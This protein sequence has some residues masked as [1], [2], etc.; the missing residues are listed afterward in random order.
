MERKARPLFH[1]WDRIK[2][3]VQLVYLNSCFNK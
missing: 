3:A 2:Q 1:H